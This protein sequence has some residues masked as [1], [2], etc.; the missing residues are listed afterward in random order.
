MLLFFLKK[1]LNILIE[2]LYGYFKRFG[3]IY[4]AYLIYDHN[5]QQSRCFGFVEFEN[6]DSVKQILQEGKH[7]IDGNVIEC[8]PVFLKSELKEIGPIEGKSNYFV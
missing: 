1:N 8:K 3:D 5:T 2:K 6:G 7:I 4:K